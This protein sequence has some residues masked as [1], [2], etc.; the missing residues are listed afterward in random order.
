MSRSGAPGHSTALRHLDD[1]GFTA[2][3]NMPPALVDQLISLVV[4]TKGQKL[5]I[6]VFAYSGFDAEAI[7]RLASN[8]SRQFGDKAQIIYVTA[9]DDELFNRYKATRRRHPLMDKEGTLEAA[10]AAET[11]IFIS[12][13]KKRT[14]LLIAQKNHH[15]FS[16]NI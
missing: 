11:D 2:V 9:S 15:I 14:S 5:A 7:D 13:K 1:V 8:I 4:E 3:D 12:P 6:G 10:I 16:A